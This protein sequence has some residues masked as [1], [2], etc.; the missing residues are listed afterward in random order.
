M[1]GNPQNV[2]LMMIVRFLATPAGVG[3]I[4]RMH[5]GGLRKLRPPAYSL[6]TLRVAPPGQPE[7]L[8]ASSRGL[9]DQ[10]AIP[11]ENAPQFSRTPAG[12]ARSARWEC[13]AIHAGQLDRIVGRSPP[14]Q[15]A[16]LPL[17]SGLSA[18]SNPAAMQPGR[19]PAILQPGLKR[20]GRA[21]ARVAGRTTTSRPERPE[22]EHRF[23]GLEVNISKSRL[24]DANG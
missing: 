19:R 10:G 16:L 9:S 17:Q 13:F 12:G 14:S 1:S 3:G 6:A 21:Q 18:P 4:S 20:V 24:T 2:E 23:L 8:E 22:H 5:T 11:P 15:P 7:G